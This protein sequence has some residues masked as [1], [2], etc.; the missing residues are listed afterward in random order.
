MAVPARTSS[1]AGAA[2]QI[3]KGAAQALAMHAKAKA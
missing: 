3:G 2:F 1:S